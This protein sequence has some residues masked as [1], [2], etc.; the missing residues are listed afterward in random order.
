MDFLPPDVAFVV[1][2]N[3]E[4]TPD[5]AE[6][7]QRPELRDRLF[8]HPAVPIEALPAWIAGADVGVIAFEPTDRNNVLGTPN[9]L[10]ECLAAGVPMVVSD[11]PEMARIVRETGA[12]V[13]CDPTNPAS[14]AAAIRSIL[15]EPTAS[16][17]ER[18]HRCRSAALAEYNWQHEFAKMR[19]LYEQAR[20][21]QGVRS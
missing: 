16:R 6:Q 5:L 11:L 17:A 20:A 10:F 3:G 2:G 8:L 12:G 14:I 18:R 1:L 19:A 21:R 13:S 15:D 9:K 7:S 4:L